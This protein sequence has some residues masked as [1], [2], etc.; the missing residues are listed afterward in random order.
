MN[1]F[2]LVF[3]KARKAWVSVAQREW[4][5]T[6]LEVRDG[7]TVE[8]LEGENALVEAWVDVVS[9]GCPHARQASLLGRLMAAFGRR[10]RSWAATAARQWH[11]RPVTLLED[12]KVRMNRYGDV[13]VQGWI[14]VRAP[15]CIHSGYPD[16]PQV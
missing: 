12:A 1:I 10:R 13:Q 6:R 2:G 5:N 11:L 8:L 9:Y 14:L 4:Q 15:Q 16:L 3:G 7:S